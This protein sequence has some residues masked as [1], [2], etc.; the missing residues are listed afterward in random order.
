M[1]E[2]SRFLEDHLALSSSAGFSDETLID[3]V[4]NDY[5]QPIQLVLR[6]AKS[7]PCDTEP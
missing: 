2:G 1:T 5:A 6:L 3:F 4:M 7:E